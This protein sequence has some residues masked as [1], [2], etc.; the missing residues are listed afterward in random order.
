MAGQDQ[1]TQLGEEAYLM[2][3]GFREGQQAISLERE[4]QEYESKRSV[5][6]QSLMTWQVALELAAEQSLPGERCS[7]YEP[8]DTEG[9][10]PT[11][12]LVRAKGFTPAMIEFCDKSHIIHVA[13]V[14]DT[15]KDDITVKPVLAGIPPEKSE[16]P[17]AQ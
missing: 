7:L 8:R 3:R 12:T 14:R 10:G 2:S 9:V 16:C 5:V 17:E 15:S 11:I 4:A 1:L 6:E 13:M